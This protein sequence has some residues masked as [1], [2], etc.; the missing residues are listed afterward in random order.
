MG[1]AVAGEDIKAFYHAKAVKYR[2]GS[3]GSDI[4]HAK[5][6]AA[7]QF[8][9]NIGDDIEQL[10]VGRQQFFKQTIFKPENAGDFLTHNPV[11][12]PNGII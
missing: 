7:L 10:G 4:S 1:I 6:L 2:A 3:L 11:F 8:F 12:S 9:L 5:K